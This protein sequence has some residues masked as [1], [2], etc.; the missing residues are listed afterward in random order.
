MSLR[1]LRRREPGKETVDGYRTDA[2]IISK[3]VIREMDE[4]IKDTHQTG[5]EHGMS[6]C[7]DK[8]NHV[9]TVGYKSIGTDRGISVPERCRKRTEK[10]IGSFHTHPNDS[11][12][13]A[14]AQDLFSSCL[15]ISNLDCVGKNRWGE[16]VCYEKKV[17]NTSCIEDAQALKSIEDV[18]HE[19]DPDV[20]PEIKR[21][22]YKEVDRVASKKFKL[23]KI[24]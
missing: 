11:E 18:F 13:A 9:V 17:K 12:A 1:R 22:L 10:Y 19:I 14:S 24:K 7:A 23:H 4:Q 3:D 16:I 15:D 8:M 6:L 2:Y 20:L 21:D 5:K